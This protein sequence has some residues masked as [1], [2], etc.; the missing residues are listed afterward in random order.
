MLAWRDD[1]IRCFFL[2]KLNFIYRNLV[3]ARLCEH[4]TGY[5]DFSA[6]H[7]FAMKYEF[8]FLKSYEIKT[9][10]CC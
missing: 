5:D 10:A 7:Y 4:E 3:R 2:Q 1:E 8:D 6:K 9:M